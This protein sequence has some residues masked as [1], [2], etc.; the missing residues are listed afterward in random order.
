MKNEKHTF[1]SPLHM[2]N[3]CLGSIKLLRKALFDK[4]ICQSSLLL[5]SA[6]KLNA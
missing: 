5:R 2:A 3:I 4:D 1:L 6:P